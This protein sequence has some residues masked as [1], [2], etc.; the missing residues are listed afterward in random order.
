MPFCE[1][2]EPSG[3]GRG[4]ERCGPLASL[5]ARMVARG[6]SGS[7]SAHGGCRPRAPRSPLVPG[8]FSSTPTLQSSPKLELLPQGPSGGATKWGAA[9]PTSSLLPKLL[10]TNSI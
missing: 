9:S 4:A 7:S 1:I 3:W 5:P 10:Q 6:G 8:L 2:L